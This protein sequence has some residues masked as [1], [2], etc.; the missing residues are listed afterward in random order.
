[1]Y[2]CM[3][4]GGF[5][6]QV[7]FFNDF[8]IEKNVDYWRMGFGEVFFIMLNLCSFSVNLV[9]GVFLC[10]VWDVLCYNFGFGF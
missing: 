6:M 8:V 4:F 5:D 1:M 3:L 7:C 10:S 2:G 9:G